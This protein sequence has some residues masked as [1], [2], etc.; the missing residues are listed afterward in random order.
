[1]LDYA[2]YTTGNNGYQGNKGHHHN[3]YDKLDGEWLEYYKVAKNFTGKVKPEDREDFLHD[4]F[5]EYNKVAVSYK[6]KDKELTTGGL[7]R[8]TQYRVA[9][10]WRQQYKHLYGHTCSQCSKAQRVK[11]KTGDLY[12]KCPKAIKLD[13]LIEDGNG[14]CTTL[15]ELLADD[16][17][18]DL[19]SRL[20]AELILQ[21]YPILFVKLAYKKYAG[22]KLDKTEKNHYYRQQEKAQKSLV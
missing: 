13:S 21:S 20:D 8:I 17:A 18:V 14:D 15:S 11:C 10:Y 3:G 22:Y 6:A 12:I 5:L 19:N 9:N 16:N 2:E 4:L 7:I 1:M